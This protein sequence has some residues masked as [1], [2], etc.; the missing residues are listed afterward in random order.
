MRIVI[1]DEHRLLLEALATALAG[2]GYTVEAATTKP[3]EACLRPLA[4]RSW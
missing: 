4:R 1:C 3:G 2:R